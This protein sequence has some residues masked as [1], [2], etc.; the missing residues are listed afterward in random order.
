MIVYHCS[1]MLFDK[2]RLDNR[3]W[4]LTTHPASGLGMFFDFKSCDYLKG[5]GKYLYAI[6]INDSFIHNIMSIHE[7]HKFSKI[8]EDWLFFQEKGRELA[9][10]YDAIFIQE[11]N[12]EINQGIILNENIVVGLSITEIQI[13]L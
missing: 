5:F 10:K 6:E 8:D 3:V 11:T 7:F 12:G 9:K 13:N 4:N 2:V 1:N